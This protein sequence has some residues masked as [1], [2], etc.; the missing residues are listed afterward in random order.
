MGQA[1]EFGTQ[2]RTRMD[3]TNEYIQNVNAKGEEIKHA[4]GKHP[5]HPR[6]THSTW[7]IPE[8]EFADFSS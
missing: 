5:H 4:T 8:P 2:L 3:D 7:L 1:Q 6:L